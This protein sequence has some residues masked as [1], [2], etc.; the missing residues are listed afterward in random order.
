MID[1]TH[2]RHRKPLLLTIINKHASHFLSAIL[3]NVHRFNE[4]FFTGKLG[5][6]FVKI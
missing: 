5:N 1:Y 3:P 2:L 4:F 6:K